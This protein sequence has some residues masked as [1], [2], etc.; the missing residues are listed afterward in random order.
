MSLGSLAVAKFLQL[1][2]LMHYIL[3]NATYASTGDQPTCSTVV[4]FEALG[5]NAHVI[6]VEPGNE[7]GTPRLPYE[8]EEMF[9]RFM[10]ACAASSTISNNSAASGVS[11]R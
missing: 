3:D 11:G 1:P 4:D 2:N 10:N 8:P 9:S 5:H 7:P 6:R